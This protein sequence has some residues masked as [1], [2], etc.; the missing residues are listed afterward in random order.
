MGLEP[1]TYSATNC[2][3]NLLSYTLRFFKSAKIAVLFVLQNTIIT[4]FK[5]L[6]L[7]AQQKPL[8]IGF[9][10]FILILK[11]YT[12]DNSYAKFYTIYED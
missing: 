2:R 7:F 1:T 4:F 5:I 11:N 12:F 8:L 10:K 3:S 9:Y 6:V